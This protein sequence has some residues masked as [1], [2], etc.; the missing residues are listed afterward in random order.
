MVVERQE[1]RKGTRVNADYMDF[2]SLM[3]QVWGVIA[4]VAFTFLCRRKRW[5]PALGIIIGFFVDIVALGVL[6][7]GGP[8]MCFGFVLFPLCGWLISRAT[9]A[10]AGCR[11]Q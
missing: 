5:A 9:L 10:I 7:G 11:R 3:V 6:T 8:E 2:L 4:V 1:I